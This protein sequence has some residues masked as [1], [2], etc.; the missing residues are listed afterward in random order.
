VALEV[1]G[2]HPLFHP[3][4]NILKNL[5]IFFGVPKFSLSLQPLSEEKGERE[6]AH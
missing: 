1:G 3:R 4:K 5:E 6:K 2:S